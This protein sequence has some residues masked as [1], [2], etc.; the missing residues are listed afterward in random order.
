MALASAFQN[1]LEI[2]RFAPAGI[3][4]AN[5]L[6]EIATKSSNLF[7]VS[8]ELAADSLLHALGQAFCLRKGDRKRLHHQMILV[9]SAK[10]TP[11]AAP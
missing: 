3:Q 10:P 8:E 6:L 9:A 1:V 7:D 2:P 4:R 5:P 11:S